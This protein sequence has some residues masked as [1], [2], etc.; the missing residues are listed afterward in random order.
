MVTCGYCG[1]KKRG[2]F[3]RIDCIHDMW[4]PDCKPYKDRLDREVAQGK[5][6]KNGYDECGRKW[7]GAEKYKGACKVCV[8]EGRKSRATKE[9][10]KRGE[11][12]V[13]RCIL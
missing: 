13:L 11:E 10:D 6:Y 2:N 9:V 12:R 3:V 1:E 5:K 8:S 4:C 7:V